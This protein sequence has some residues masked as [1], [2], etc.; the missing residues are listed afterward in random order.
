VAMAA[1]L[2]SPVDQSQALGALASVLDGRSLLREHQRVTQ[3]RLALCRLPHF[4]VY[5]SIEAVRSAAAAHMYVGEYEQ[6]L[7]GL[8]EAEDLAVR[9]QVVEQQ[10]NALGLQV[11][12]FFRLDRWDEVLATE[13]KWRELERKYPRERVGEMCFYIALSASVHA[14]RGDHQRAAAYAQES[15]DFMVYVSGTPDQWQRNQFY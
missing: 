12:C 6:A 8:R 9:A 7:V 1:E 5:E 15:Y 4:D 3:Q 10:A 11:Q 14:L 2:D 13:T